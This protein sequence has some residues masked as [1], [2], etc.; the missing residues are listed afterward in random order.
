[1]MGTLCVA[2]S[3]TLGG[4]D[5]TSGFHRRTLSI[6]GP[7]VIMGPILDMVVISRDVEGALCEESRWCINSCLLPLFIA[8][9]RAAALPPRLLHHGAIKL[10]VAPTHNLCPLVRSPIFSV[11]PSLWL[12][13]KRDRETHLEIGGSCCAYTVLPLLPF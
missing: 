11:P 2:S 3:L 6:A 10:V 13:R 8:P 7:L 1:M 5:P 12:R 4:S 9:A